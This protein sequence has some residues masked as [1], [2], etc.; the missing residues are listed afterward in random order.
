MSLGLGATCQGEA[1]EH[2]VVLGLVSV[3]VSGTRA[4]GITGLVLS[5]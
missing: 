3:L 4:Q 2:K 5:H 1:L